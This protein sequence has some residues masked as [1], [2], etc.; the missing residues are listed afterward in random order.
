M[1]DLAFTFP[2]GVCAQSHP[3][4]D[5]SCKSYLKHAAPP[6]ACLALFDCPLMVCACPSDSRDLERRI[7]KGYNFSS[8]FSLLVAPV[9]PDSIPALA[10][11]RADA[12]LKHI[13]YVLFWSLPSRNRGSA[14]RRW[15]RRA[16][17]NWGCCAPSLATCPA[18]KRTCSMQWRASTQ[19]VSTQTLLSHR[20]PQMRQL[21]AE[22]GQT[23]CGI[24]H[25]LDCNTMSL[26]QHVTLHRRILLARCL[27]NIAMRCSIF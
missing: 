3:G 13:E 23:R 18:E 11:H 12:F 8:G 5:V 25:L 19:Q 14:I 1:R 9:C 20:Q 16:H 2:K 27:Q 15:W 26:R 4:S 17:L 6:C 24:I 22:S 21:L 7:Y 10:M